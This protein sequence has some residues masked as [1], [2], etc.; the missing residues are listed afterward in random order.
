MEKNGIYNITLL[1]YY[2]CD[3]IINVLIKSLLLFDRFF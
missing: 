3:C 1:L 2:N